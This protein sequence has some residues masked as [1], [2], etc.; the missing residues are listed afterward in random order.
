MCDCVFSSLWPY[1]QKLVNDLPNYFCFPPG[2]TVELH[3]PASLA[4]RYSHLTV[5]VNGM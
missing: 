5:V 1:G 4:V 2:H 3:I